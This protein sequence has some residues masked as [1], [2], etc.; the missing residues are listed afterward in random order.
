[1]STLL[2]EHEASVADCLQ[3]CADTV[4]A[5][6]GNRW[7]F[8]LRSAVPLQVTACLEGEWLRWCAPLSLPSASR[9]GPAVL[10]RMLACNGN[11]AAAVKF[12]LAAAPPLP[13]LA[14]EVPLGVEEA[15]LRDLAP[16]I[17]GL[18]DGFSR[19]VQK[20]AG[21]QLEGSPAEAVQAGDSS[22]ELSSELAALCKET[23]WPMAERAAHYVVFELDVAGA[24]YQAVARSW[25]AGL[26][27]EVELVNASGVG[28]DKQQALNVLLLH[29]SHSVRMARA[30]ARA[31]DDVT[32]Y[33]WEVLL[34][35]VA[36]ARELDH[37]LAALSVAC[38]LSGREACAFQQD[39]YL[40][41]SYL[42]FRGW[43]S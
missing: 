33:G 15:D 22:E 8:A 1:M 25:Q 32:A 40:A 39:D 13:C 10:Q 17:A 20:F 21:G 23:G 24:F 41:R 37:A 12:T 31:S 19:A 35:R 42:M 11:L 34:D 30:T 7:E 4:R 9:P 26:R 43:C 16:R 36:N 3:Q 6:G 38:R 29:A 2:Q 27:L 14:A 18:C 28:G 5:V